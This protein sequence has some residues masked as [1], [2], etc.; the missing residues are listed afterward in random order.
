M[1]IS[2]TDAVLYVLAIVGAFGVGFSLAKVLDRLK[3]YSSSR[4]P[5]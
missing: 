3:V 5:S 1:D 2:T 4:R